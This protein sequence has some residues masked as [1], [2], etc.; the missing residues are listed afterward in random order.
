MSPEE[1]EALRRKCFPDANPQDWNLDVDAIPQQGEF[2]GDGESPRTP[3][4]LKKLNDRHRLAAHLQIGGMT[5]KQ[6]CDELG[7]NESYFS[8]IARDPAYILLKE[9]LHKQFLESSM[10]ELHNKVHRAS[11]DTFNTI[12]G[13]MMDKEEAPHAV[14][15]SAAKELFARQMPAVNREEREAKIVLQIDGFGEKVQSIKDAAGIVDAEFSDLP[16]EEQVRLLE[17]KLDEPIQAPVH[18]GLGA[19]R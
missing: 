15:L 8:V 16:P 7:W 12:H 5:N 11:T 10:E 17:E 19:S 4:R 18:K 6:V 14:R 3:Q 2:G 9:D 13:I 1:Q